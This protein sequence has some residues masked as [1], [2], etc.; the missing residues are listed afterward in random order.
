MEAYKRKIEEMKP[1]LRDPNEKIQKFAQHYISDLEK[2]IDAEQQRADEEIIL[3]KYQY[4]VR[5]EKECVLIMLDFP[6]GK[7]FLDGLEIV[8]GR[9]NSG[10]AQ[11]SGRSPSH[12][13]DARESSV[14]IGKV[15]NHLNRN[16]RLPV[17]VITV[18]WF[19]S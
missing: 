7:K 9:A 8:S 6:E 15:E 16:R 1:W 4:G 13:A 3:R 17:L 5:D 19:L 10:I 18:T 2:Q 11:Q 12:H 14:I